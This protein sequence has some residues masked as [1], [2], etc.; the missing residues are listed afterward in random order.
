MITLR[1]ITREVVKEVLPFENIDS[2]EK[3]LR[4]KFEKTIQMCGGNM[5]KLYDGK[6]QISFPDEEKEFVKIVLVQLAREEGLS[7]KIW[8]NKDEN[9]SLEEVHDFIQYFADYL[10]T[11]GYGEA[12]IQG[13]VSALDMMFQLSAREKLEQCHR[14]LDCY[15]E[16]LTPYIYTQQLLCLNSLFDKLAAESVRSTVSSAIYC[17]E[18]AE[19]LKK[20]MEAAEVDNVKD[21]YGEE[22][23]PIRDEYVERDKQVLLY[24]K[25]HPEIRKIVEEQIGEPIT[26]IWKDAEV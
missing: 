2:A 18:L 13:V 26:E 7:H 19:V 10:G 8:E 17:G 12:D 24:L 6:K 1:Q 22:G 14:M 25:K 5:E 15:A 23:D 4:R 16:N 20:C 9:L 3:K 11:K 21:M